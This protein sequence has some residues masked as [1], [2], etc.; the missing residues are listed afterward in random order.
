MK[1]NLITTLLTMLFLAG[2]VYAQTQTITGKVTEENG[3]PMAFVNVIIKGTTTGTT[4]DF[5]GKFSIEIKFGENETVELEASYIGYDPMKITVSKSM[6]SVNF[7][8]A[9][10][11]IMGKEVVVSASRVSESLME[12]PV[13]I[14]TINARQVQ[15]SSSGDFYQSLG[16]LK[17]VDVVSSSLGFKTVNMRGFN[18]TAAF[19]S[20]QFVDGMDNA[21]PGLNFPIGN[22][23]GPSELDIHS[24]E[25]ISGAASALY[26]ANAFQGVLNMNTKDPYRYNGLDV[27]V[28]GGHPNF[29]N[30]DLRFAQTLGAKEKFTFKITGGY[31][32]GDDWEATDPEANLYG[33]IETDVDL[34]KIV[35]EKQYD[36]SETEE[37]RE[38]F[39]ALNTYLGFYPVAYP[40]MITL[41]T[42]GYMETD[43][44]DP[45]VENLKT[46]L[47]LYYKFND[48]LKIEYLLKYG[49]GSTIYQ[50]TNRYAI[51]NMSIL[52]NK[53]Q[54]SGKNWFLKAYTTNENTGD[55]Y[56]LVF[57]AINISKEGISDYVGDYLE[58]YFDIIDTLSNNFEDEALQ[59]MADS[60][61]R[62]ALIAAQN[63]WIE[64]GSHKFDS[65][66]NTIIENPDLQKG[67]KFLDESSLQHV[68]GQY[69]FSFIKAVDLLAGASFRRYNPQSFGTIFSDTLVNPADTFANGQNDPEAAYVDISSYEYGG[70]V[71]ATKKVMNDKL[72]FTVSIRFDKNKNYDLQFSPRLAVS[73]SKNDHNFRLSFQ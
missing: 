22:M 42:P 73:Y 69:N 36:L 39:A 52:Q 19:R 37:D 46:S 13:E 50:G 49:R 18:A 61:H 54:V 24:I 45:K 47:G 58:A 15:S 60:A 12:A 25:I 59:W 23:V 30:A 35:V 40:G 4:T 43:L 65:L 48:S 71:Q 38:D 3:E 11:S 7:K 14:Q 20:V 63:S 41:N 34:T 27:M 66:Y 31:L 5:D 32:N 57:T 9:T 21:A 72:K 68:E 8:L 53:L 1:T 29:I 56:D 62:A 51:K 44:V 55:S 64:P 2:S 6:T 26:G 67:S 33:D 17:G 16:N 70:Y 10:T 28:R